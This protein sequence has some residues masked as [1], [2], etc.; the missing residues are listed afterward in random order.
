[1][2]ARRRLGL[3]VVVLAVTALSAA[4]VRAGNGA[5]AEELRAKAEGSYGMYCYPGEGSWSCSNWPLSAEFQ[6]DTGEVT[7]LFVRS[8]EFSDDG[9]SPEA[10][11]M[12]VDFVDAVCLD[13]DGVSGFVA[14]VAAL[15]TFR[16]VSPAEL[17]TCS[18]TGGLEDPCELDCY[19][20][21][22]VP[23]EPPPTPAPSPTSAPTA[24][25]SPSPSPSST[26]GQA[27]SATPTAS[28]SGSPT[29]ASGSASATSSAWPSMTPSPTGSADESVE[30]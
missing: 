25:P 3:L 30:V 24:T 10:E 14:R 20:V 8:D 28:A 23:R 19:W 4:A 27:S 22:A 16:Q 15:T 12:M 9:M 26:P 7:H 18:L 21:D 2:P 17:R 6:P 29:A 1:M 5:T 13:P 11:S